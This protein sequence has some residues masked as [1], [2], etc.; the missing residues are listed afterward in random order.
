MKSCPGSC[1]EHLDAQGGVRVHC[2]E[3]RFS[4]E[5]SDSY[6]EY[7]PVVLKTARSPLTECGI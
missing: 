1:V 6:S 3:C 5:I 2:E 7:E 4:N